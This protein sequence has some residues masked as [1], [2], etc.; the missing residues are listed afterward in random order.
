M[1]DGKPLTSLARSGFETSFRIDDYATYVLLEATDKHGKVLGRS[2]VTKTIISSPLSEEV[3]AK[4]A[5]WL[6]QFETRTGSSW[7]SKVT[8]FIAIVASLFALA[9]LAKRVFRL[10][11]KGVF[12]NH[13][14]GPAYELVPNQNLDSFAI[15]EDEEGVTNK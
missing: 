3:L 13:Q 11:R 1:E 15:G 7:T 8:Y 4:E 5:K 9:V 6:Q 10:W 12:S 2:N 14:A